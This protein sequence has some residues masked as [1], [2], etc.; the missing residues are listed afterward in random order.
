VQADIAGSH[1]LLDGRI[2]PSL[3]RP[4]TVEAVAIR[5]G[6][7]VA[8]GTPA[9]IEALAEPGTPRLRLGGRTVLPGLI[10]AHLHLQHYA[11]S[12]DQ[13]DCDTDTLEECLARLRQRG[14]AQ[15]PGA[16][17][18]GHGWDQNRWGRYGS[19]QELDAALPSNPAF[20]TARSLHAAWVNSR[21][22]ALA[23]VRASTADPPGGKIGRDASGAPTGML[24][25]NAQRLVSQAA[26]EAS[27]DRLAELIHQ[28][29]STLWAFGLTGVHDFDGPPCLRALQ[30]LRENGRLGLRVLKHVPAAELEHLL[31][32][33]LRTGFGDEWIRLGNVK[34]FA[35]GA[36][37][38]RT[39]AMLDPY[40]EEPDNLGMLLVDG[41][42]LA[43]I[44]LRAAEGGWALAVH[45]I[46]DRA[47]HQVLNALTTIRSHERRL[48]LAPLRH[49]IEHLQ[50]M[51][52]DDL[53]R[54]AQLGVFASMQPSHATSDMLMADRYWGDRTQ[55][56]YAWRSQIEAGAT[57]V[58]GSDAPVESPNPFWGLYAALTRRRLDG[59][60]GPSGWHPEHRLTLREAMA[61]FT[62]GPA[63]A[64][65]REDR[66]GRLQ[67]GCWADLIVLDRDP[68][69]CEPEQLAGLRPAGT[70][71]A[72]EWRLRE[73]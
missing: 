8:I 5:S 7:V 43:D 68:F 18:R 56:A 41:E 22:L 54:P 50:L 21:A 70:M 58:F 17:V 36:L 35:D 31:A 71:V 48:G 40:D 2:Y 4:A 26:G 63:A 55:Y 67:P 38:P 3:D 16:W 49:R 42:E 19:L 34:V 69:D 53:A 73:F 57:L 14:Q 39:A 65:G 66:Q 44:G 13:V 46:G 10:D 72:G 62:L 61:A 60:P 47:N 30:L 28:A 33:G 51:H 64:A 27:P 32:L 23:G 1:L 59:T 25:E 11:L 52:P 29:Q 12:L 20:L 45:A 15:A 37:G 24:F 6:R 9:Q